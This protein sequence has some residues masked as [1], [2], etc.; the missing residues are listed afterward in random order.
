M[1]IVLVDPCLEYLRLCFHLHIEPKQQT[2]KD[3]YGSDT[4]SED[5]NGLE[6]DKIENSEGGGEHISKPLC[7]VWKFC[8]KW[9][10]SVEVLYK[11][12]NGHQILTRVHFHYNPKVI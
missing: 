9:S 7:D 8:K 10:K 12:M 6:C 2:R 4:D 3:R 1:I 5:G 11:N